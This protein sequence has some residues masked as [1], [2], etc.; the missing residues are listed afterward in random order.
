M[1]PR[2]LGIWE[3]HLSDLGDSRHRCEIVDQGLSL[4]TDQA[5][6]GLVADLA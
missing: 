6:V 3:R 5:D 4:G 1:L 2:H